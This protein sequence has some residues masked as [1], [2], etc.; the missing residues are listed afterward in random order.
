MQE[1][2]SVAFIPCGVYTNFEKLMLPFDLIS[3]IITAVSILAV[4]LTFAG[5]NRVIPTDSAKT[6]YIDVI[7]IIFGISMTKISIRNS[8][9]FFIMIYTLFCLIMRTSYQGV[10]FEM[11]TNDMRPRTPQSFEELNDRN[12]S[13]L[14]LGEIGDETK[15]FFH[16]MFEK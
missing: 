3:W 4:L 1:E 5:I 15:D 12:Y 6:S 16:G 14:V 7:A 11:M 10:F 9:R 2:N 13:L 8:I